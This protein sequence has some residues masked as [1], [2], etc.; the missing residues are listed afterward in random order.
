MQTEEAKMQCEADAN[1]GQ[2]VPQTD[3]HI[4]GPLKPDSTV[5]GTIAATAYHIP[6]GIFSG[7]ACPAIIT[8]IC[9]LLSLL[10]ID[11]M[12]GVAQ[13]HDL[14]LHGCFFGLEHFNCP[15]NQ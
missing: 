11:C 8:V 1:H 5:A 7:L 2:I 3:L 10:L 15:S 13:T 12:H 14:T 6:E 9:L 4:M